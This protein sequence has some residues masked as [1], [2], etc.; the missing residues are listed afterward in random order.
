MTHTDSRVVLVTGSAS[1]IGRATA[2]AF[3]DA[4]WTV[5]ATDVD[6]AGLD[7]LA[8][9]GCRTVA[10]DVTDGRAVREALA[11]VESEAGR[12][13]CLVNNAGVGVAGPLPAVP[14]DAVEH[15]LEVNAL[16]PLR[17]TRAA[18]P[19]LERTGG[20][21]L[22]VSS[23]LGR[24][25]PPG[26][27]AYA[28]SKHALVALTDGFRRELAGTGVRVVGVEP[29][30]VDTGFAA[31]ARGTRSSPDERHDS[32][33]TRRTAALLER[34]SFLEGGPL[35]VPPERVAATLLRAATVDDPRTRYPVGL[36][37][38]AVGATRWLPPRV[39]DAGFRALGGLAVAI[40]RLSDP[41]D[42][43]NDR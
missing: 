26:L 11:R 35:A 20:R 24:V 6:E 14:L 15:G 21:V 39:L 30:W 38:R 18:L 33:A 29:A 12:L 4:G 42:R 22:V 5:Y 27:G 10:L 16:G 19:L 23:V 40:D 32:P 8:A 3:A 43:R 1:G 13:D 2:L 37:G 28:A 31:A 7:P 17:V 36:A 34:L 9:A 25:T 41:F